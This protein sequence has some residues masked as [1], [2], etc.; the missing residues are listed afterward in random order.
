MEEE[1]KKEKE[2]TKQTKKSEKQEEERE[3]GTSPSFGS[4]WPSS[5]LFFFCV[6]LSI[7]RLSVAHSPF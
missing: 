2:K 3:R 6:M 4:W 5:S 1:E 7:H